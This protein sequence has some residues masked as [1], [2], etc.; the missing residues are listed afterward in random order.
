[1]PAKTLVKN[2]CSQ[3]EHVS[4][5]FHEANSDSSQSSDSDD[6]DSDES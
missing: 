6:S 1:M 5:N 3:L 4:T 2:G